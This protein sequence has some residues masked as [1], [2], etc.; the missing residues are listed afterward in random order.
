M[1]NHYP[2]LNNKKLEQFVNRYGEEFGSKILLQQLITNIF[3][4]EKE[5]K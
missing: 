4:L 3:H 2:M 5:E 1:A